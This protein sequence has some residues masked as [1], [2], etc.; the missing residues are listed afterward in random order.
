MSLFVE[1][2]EFVA[3][4]DTEPASEDSCYPST[5][6][7]PHEQVRPESASSPT[8]SESP[9]SSI[10]ESLSPPPIKLYKLSDFQGLT[11]RGIILHASAC[12]W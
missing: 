6:S 7:V 4:T 5:D 10:R 2:V 9:N 3:Y 11:Y 12:Q 1:L 8:G